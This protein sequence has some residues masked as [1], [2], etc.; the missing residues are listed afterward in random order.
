AYLLLVFLNVLGDG[1]YF[2][3]IAF[4]NFLLHLVDQFGV[5]LRKVVDEV[6]RVLYL[7]GNT[8]GKFAQR[9]HF[10]G[11]DELGLGGFKFG[12]GFLQRIVLSLD[13]RIAL[14]QRLVGF[15]TLTIGKQQ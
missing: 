2:V 13:L 10:F 14:Q 5:Y 7:M 12:Q 6:E 4:G 15:F 9:G 1:F 11:L 3:Q 8:G